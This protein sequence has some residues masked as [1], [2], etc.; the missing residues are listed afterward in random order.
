MNRSEFTER[1]YSDG[2]FN[3]AGL[4]RS[5]EYEKDPLRFGP[6]ANSYTKEVRRAEVNVDIP[7]GKKLRTSLSVE[8]NQVSYA[9]PLNFLPSDAGQQNLV[10]A[11]LSYGNRMGQGGPENFMDAFGAIF[12]LGLADVGERI[13][14]LPKPQF[15]WNSRFSMSQG[16]RILGSDYSFTLLSSG[17]SGRLEFPRRHSLS[18]GI[19]ANRGFN[20]PITQQVATNRRSLGLRGNYAREFRGDA[21]VGATMS[22]SYLMKKTKR[23][24]WVGEVFAEKA[25]VWDDGRCFSQTGLGGNLYY[26]FWRFPLPLGFGYTYST[27]D[28]DEQLSFAIGGMF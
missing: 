5:S 12:G 13:K 21:G 25:S 16:T 11:G 27:K 20:L 9:A 14:S 19:N 1:I 10:S 3:T 26:R 7:V 18:L 23:G 6:I 28:R 2:G 4:G 17:L 8:T 22:F 15:G 24:L